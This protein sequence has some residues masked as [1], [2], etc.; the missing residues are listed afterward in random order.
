MT[1]SFRSDR[2]DT[3]AEALLRRREKI[4]A[5]LRAGLSKSVIAARAGVTTK[6]VAAVAREMAEEVSPEG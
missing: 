1:A 3:S 5:L 4:R 6:T 2:K